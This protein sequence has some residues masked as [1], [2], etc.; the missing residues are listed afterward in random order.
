MKPL[1]RCLRLSYITMLHSQ[2]KGSPN[3]MDMSMWKERICRSPSFL[4]LGHS[5][6]GKN[7]SRIAA[8]RSQR[9]LH[10]AGSQLL[11]CR[12][13]QIPV[14]S[15]YRLKTYYPRSPVVATKCQSILFAVQS[16]YTV[17]HRSGYRVARPA[18]I[19][20]YQSSLGLCSI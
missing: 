12:R 6:S 13:L 10:L 8:Q 20:P 1:H 2:L 4:P 11:S 5:R 18:N 16:P 19:H 9:L 14:V 15:T 7:A 3:I 17:F